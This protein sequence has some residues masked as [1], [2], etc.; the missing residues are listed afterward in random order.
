MLG[1]KQ[2]STAPHSGDMQPRRKTYAFV[3]L[4]SRDCK[5]GSSLQGLT[6]CG[7]PGAGARASD[8][9]IFLGVSQAPGRW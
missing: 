2:R 5:S 1:S 9:I 6:G 4:G 7:K 8:P 3:F